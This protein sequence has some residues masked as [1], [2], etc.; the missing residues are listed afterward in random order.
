MNR[1][2]PVSSPLAVSHR[3]PRGAR[4]LRAGTWS[5]P[6]LA[7]C[8]ALALGWAYG[9]DSLDRLARTL[10]EIPLGV[11]LVDLW[12]L[13]IALFRR[14]GQSPLRVPVKTP[15]I[16]LGLHLGVWL[17]TRYLASFEVFYGLRT[18]G[19]VEG[20]HVLRP[21]VAL[22]LVLLSS[23]CLVSTFFEVRLVR[24]VLISEKTAVPAVCRHDTVT[25]P[26]AGK[27]HVYEA[28]M[29]LSRLGYDVGE[30]DGVLDES[31]GAALS[32]FQASRGMDP[33]GNLTMLT[34]VELRNRWTGREEPVVAPSVRAISQR[35]VRRAA[36]CIAGLWNRKT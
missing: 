16:L 5:V 22:L 7:I 2:D 4:L 12:A 35:A 19:E 6:V 17:W 27:E 3:S 29:L 36:A 9:S 11:V 33:S 21:G 30:I 26:P 24:W 8:L 18:I 15:V 20:I 13:G 14:P 32:A 1:L 28:Q 10:A 25:D 34:V 23:L 31:T